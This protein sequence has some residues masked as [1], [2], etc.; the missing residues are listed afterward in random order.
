MSSLFVKAQ[1]RLLSILTLLSIAYSQLA[2][3]A[4]TATEVAEA[5][6]AKRLQFYQSISK[7]SVDFK[8]IKTLKE[9]GVKLE[10]E[11]KLEL[12]RPSQV[13]WEIKKP[14]RVLI[15][16][17]QKQIR[18]ESGEGKD[19]SIQVVK[20]EDIP[21][22]RESKSIGGL[23][24]WL[25]LDAH[26]LSEQ[27]IVTSSQAKKLMFS[28][29]QK[30]NSVFKSIELTL[31]STGHLEILHIWEGSGDEIEI[32]FSAPRIEKTSTKTHK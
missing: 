2:I 25:Q 6:L 14:S 31:S 19:V 8:Q 7:L 5:D 18:I 12:I 3:S 9:L 15:R 27:Y 16:F 13:I 32:Q 22:G 4:P 30:D 20:M 24:A 29:K 26:A 1:S 23:M 17:D 10:S 11:G 28:P 21:K